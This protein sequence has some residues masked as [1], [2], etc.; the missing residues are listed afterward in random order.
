VTNATFFLTRVTPARGASKAWY[1]RLVTDGR[2][3]G[4][5]T[6][7]EAI[8]DPFTA[9]RVLARGG[10]RR[11]VYE[12]VRDAA[13]VEGG[14]SGTLAE[15]GGRLEVPI[16]PTKVIGIG[17]NFRAHAAELDHA[18]PATPL[19][20]FKPPSCLV[21]SGAAIELPP[22][23]DRVD[24][25]GELVVV[26]GRRLRHAEPSEAEAAVSGVCLGNDVSC[27]DLQRTDGQ[28]TRAKGFDTFGPVGP[29]VRLVEGFGQVPKG[30]RI[31]T[32]VGDALRQDAPLSDMVFSVG[33]VLAHLSACMT[34]EP[35]DAVFM[36]TPAGVGPLA[37]GEVVRVECAGFDLGRLVNPVVG[38][39]PRP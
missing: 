25:E 37:A 12:I 17:R 4:P 24:Y 21:P 6:P 7:V 10:D 38:S 34:L 19:S 29:F 20:F 31:Q 13:A 22:G 16:A 5:D 11:S 8:E 36:G 3:P 15:L 30:A 32:Y 39:G 18:V 35:G 23:D 14:P 28:W 27:R 9:A 33:A 1:V 26:V 2:A